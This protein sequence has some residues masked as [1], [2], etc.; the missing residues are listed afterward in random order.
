MVSRP[1]YTLALFFSR[2]PLSHS[3]GINKPL[4]ALVCFPSL[5]FYGEIITL[6]CHWLCLTVKKDSLIFA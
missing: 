5:S 4:S 6:I 3:H 2:L 1:L